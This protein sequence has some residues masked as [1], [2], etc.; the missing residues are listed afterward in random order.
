M[1]QTSSPNVT[2]LGSD[3]HERPMF[4]NPEGLSPRECETL[5]V[6]VA[7]LPGQP[8]PFDAAGVE[9]GPQGR[10]QG[11]LTSQPLLSIRRRTS[12]AVHG[13]GT[14]A[15]AACKPRLPARTFDERAVPQ[16]HASARLLDLSGT[17]P[18]VPGTSSPTRARS[19]PH[20]TRTCPQTHRQAL[21]IGAML[22]SV[23][24]LLIA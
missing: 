17:A 2:L 23:G 20:A 14:H 16:S 11:F 1:V 5:G 6:L 24:A 15:L 4:A 19:K 8:R 9:V 22:D 7:T 10:T 12:A 21:T 18:R 3:C 13:T